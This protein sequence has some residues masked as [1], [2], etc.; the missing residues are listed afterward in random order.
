M[1]IPNSAL[2]EISG[3]VGNTGSK[4]AFTALANGSSNTVFAASQTAL[5]AENTIGG[6]GRG[7]ADVSQVTTTQSNDTLQLT[8]TWTASGAGGTIY[9]VGVFNN[10]TSGGTMLARTVLSSSKTIAAGETYA[11]TYKVKFA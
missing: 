6:L 10:A 5:V 2:A 9:E 8:K 4:T 7:A 1:G 11:L 3:L